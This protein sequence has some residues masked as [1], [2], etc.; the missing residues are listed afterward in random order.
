MLETSDSEKTFAW[1]MEQFMRL[2]FPVDQAGLLAEGGASWHD[3]QRLIE[4]D[5]PHEI[6]F[7]ILRSSD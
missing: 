7:D 5:C 4:D 3:G 1:A 2:G 6:A